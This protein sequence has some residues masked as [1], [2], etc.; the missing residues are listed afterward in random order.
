MISMASSFF[1]HI[2]LTNLCLADHVRE[3]TVSCALD[4]DSVEWPELRCCS[5]QAAYS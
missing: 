5:H 3:Y 1:L 4:S 2:A